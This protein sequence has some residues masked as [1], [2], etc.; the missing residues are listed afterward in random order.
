VEKQYSADGL[1]EKVFYWVK[2][3]QVS[4]EEYRAKTGE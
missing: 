2:G 1:V 4:A 3:C